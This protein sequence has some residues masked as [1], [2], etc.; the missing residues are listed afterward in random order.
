MLMLLWP[1]LAFLSHLA[2]DVLGVARD[3]WSAIAIR[4]LLY[5]MPIL[6]VMFLGKWRR[7]R[8]LK[9]AHLR[10]PYMHVGTRYLI[11]NAFADAEGLSFVAGESWSFC[12]YLYSA[13]DHGLFLAVRK[14]DGTELQ[15][16]LILEGELNIVANN[17]EHYVQAAS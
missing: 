2:A 6:A 12:G 3:S 9:E 15:I 14:E 7:F 1:V 13:D 5:A 4:L 10:W 16:R 8:T 17:L 11:R